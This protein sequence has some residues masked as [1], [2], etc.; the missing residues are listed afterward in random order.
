MRQQ[1]AKRA[2]EPHDWNRPDFK[3]G[4]DAERGIIEV[5]YQCADERCGDIDTERLFIDKPIPTQL[6]CVKCLSAGRGGGFNDRGLPML[7]MNKLGSG[8]LAN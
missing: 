4:N 8:V 5:V 3:V 7:P 2:V 1:A 6:M